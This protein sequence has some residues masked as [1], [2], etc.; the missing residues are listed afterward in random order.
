[1]LQEINLGQAINDGTGDDL[2]TAFLKVIANF[3]YLE[4]EITQPVDA[5]NVGAVEQG[6]F[7]E[8]IDNILY[9]KSIVA[10]DNI[11]IQT[12]PDTII[13]ST[14]QGL[15][16]KNNDI[17]NVGNLLVKGTITL[18]P[19]TNSELV[20]TTNGLHFGIVQ[21]SVYAPPSMFGLKGDVVGRSPDVG[22]LSPD[23]DPAKV[24]GVA[25]KD[26]NR[27]VNNFDFGSINNISSPLQYILSQIGVNF[28]TVASATL[29]NIDL[30][31][32]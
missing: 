26:L 3:Q 23:Y 7:K 31:G 19:T 16:L 12:T 6:V 1:M 10:G 14:T 24:D 28:G 20:G 9:F 32:I 25:V 2:R 8:K 18:D 21:G 17:E 4:G 30:G 15:D 11:E 5:A 27:T 13:V 22:E 29:I